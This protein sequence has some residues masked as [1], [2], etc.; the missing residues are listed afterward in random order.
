[1]VEGEGDGVIRYRVTK[2]VGLG[3]VCVLR[4]DTRREED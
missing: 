3:V 1:M 4:A 2:N